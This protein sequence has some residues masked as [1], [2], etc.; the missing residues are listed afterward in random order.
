MRFGSR[1]ILLA[2][3]AL[4]AGTGACLALALGNAGAADKRAAHGGRRA[5]AGGRGGADS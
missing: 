5:G 4:I 1:M 2:A 3:T